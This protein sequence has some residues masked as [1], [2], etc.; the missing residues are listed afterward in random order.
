MEK[1][2]KNIKIGSVISSFALLLLLRHYIKKFKKISTQNDN[3]KQKEWDY[4][5][6]RSLIHSNSIPMPAM[7]VEMNVLDRNI[8]K[9]IQIVQSSNKT[10]RIA[11]KSI[12]VPTITNYILHRAFPHAKGLMCYC[13]PEAQ[14]YAQF[15]QVYDLLVAYPTV[16]PSD[17][18]I[19]WELSTIHLT[20]DYFHFIHDDKKEV[21]SGFVKK[22]F[23][24]TLM[25]D[26]V[27]HLE[28]L[29]NFWDLK[30]NEIKEKRPELYNQYQQVKLRI[31]IDVDLSYRPFFGL[32]HFGAHRSPIRTINNFEIIVKSALKFPHLKIVGVMTYEAQIAGVP[33]LNPYTKLLNPI[34]QILQKFSSKNVLQKRVEILKVLSK[35]NIKLEFF[36][37]GGTGNIQQACSDPSLS[38]VTAGS[39]F[40][41]CCLMDYYSSNDNECAL[42]FAIQVTRSCEI[43]SITCQSG[44]FIASGSSCWDKFVFSHHFNYQLKLICLS[45]RAPTIFLPDDLK[46]IDQEGFGEV[47]TPIIGKGTKNVKLGDPIFC[48]PAKAGEIAENFNYYYLK[49]NDE[50][51]C[52]A[53]TYRG[54]GFRFF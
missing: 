13:V 3:V 43:N 52:T 35:N 50:L 17:L 40:F 29:N 36:N 19:T 30:L 54:D 46:V 42:S 16:Q 44:G 5:T 38:E 12:R 20:D 51:L 8:D 14:Y 31:C 2:K 18:L 33:N 6:C 9:V 26:C 27:E 21:L 47:Q 7:F 24:I 25:I 45:N 1:W 37:G 11:S 39:G 22:K 34:I 15:H 48:R 4:N 28:I 53:N 23:D 10:I 32:L 41:Q 49:R